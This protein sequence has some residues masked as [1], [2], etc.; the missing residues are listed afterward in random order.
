VN[1]T[2]A[3]ADER[4][5]KEFSSFEKPAVLKE[6]GVTLQSM[7]EPTRSNDAF[8]VKDA[9][10]TASVRSVF[11]PLFSTHCEEFNTVIFSLASE[12]T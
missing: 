6:P 1:G 2:C 3:R 12:Q 8:T 9:L 7:I 11:V 4:T 10:G 5:G